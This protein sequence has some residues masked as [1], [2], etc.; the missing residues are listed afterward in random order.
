MADAEDIFG[1]V[2]SNRAY[3]A[4]WL[5]WALGHTLEDERQWVEGRKKAQTDGSGSPCL[6]IYLGSLVGFAGI[7]R[8]DPVSKSCN[9]GYYLAESFQGRGIVTRACRSLLDYAFDTLGMNRVQ[10]S[11]NPQNTGSIAIPERLGFVY[12]GVQRQAHIL[13]GQFHDLAVYSM[14]SSE[15][16]N[17]AESERRVAQASS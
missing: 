1:L 4:R 6:I 12:E 13:N 7:D 17:P 11:A 5:H 9:L 14:L 8:I 16:A 3:L 15:W 2:D 10:I